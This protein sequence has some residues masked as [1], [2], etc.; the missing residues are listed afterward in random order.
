VYLFETVLLGQK[1][2][3]LFQ[4]TLNGHFLPKV[5]ILLKAGFKLL[6]FPGWQLPRQ[7]IADLFQKLIR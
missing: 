7:V 4:F 1:S 5:R 2:Q 6:F 3:S